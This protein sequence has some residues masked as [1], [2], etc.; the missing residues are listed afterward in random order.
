MTRAEM[1]EILTDLDVHFVTPDGRRSGAIEVSIPDAEAEKIIRAFKITGARPVIL[2]ELDPSRAGSYIG[3]A[4][5]N[6]HN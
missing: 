4:F 1:I 6:W 2:C 3:R 5:S